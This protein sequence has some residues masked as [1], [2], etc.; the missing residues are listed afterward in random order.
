MVTNTCIKKIKT[1]MC[2]KVTNILFPFY[3]DYYIIIMITLVTYMTALLTVVFPVFPVL[4]H[5][6]VADMRDLLTPFLVATCK[7][8]TCG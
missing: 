8:V 7:K 3:T 6:L 2:T 5:L 4:N 1:I